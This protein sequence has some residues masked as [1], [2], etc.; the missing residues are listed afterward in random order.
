M[1]RSKE[2]RHL[3]K[4]PVITSFMRLKWGRI[5]AH[6][7]SNILFYTILVIC[8]TSYIFCT[9]GGASIGVRMPNCTIENSTGGEAAIELGQM[10]VYQT[11][12]WWALLV[13]IILL[14]LRELFQFLV[15]GLKYFISIENLIEL[16]LIISVALLQ[17]YGA[18]G[19][20]LDMKR[21]LS[22][23]ALMLSWIELITM[24][25]RHPM[26]A[27]YNTYLTMLYRVLQTFLKFLAWYSFFI[28]GFALSFYILL[29]KDEPGVTEESEY[30]F[31]DDIGLCIVKTFSMFV[32]ELEFSDLPLGSTF[33]YVFFLIFV[34]L[35]VVVLMNLLNGL[36]VSD[37]GLIREEAEIYAHVCRV[38]VI[39]AAEATI[40]GDP[41]R[42]LTGPGKIIPTC[43]LRR[44][45]GSALRL[46]YVFQ[47]L[48]GG[49]GIMLF[50]TVLPNKRLEITPNK[51]NIVCSPCLSN[52]DVG[53]D[54]IRS[55][56]NLVYSLTQQ[57]AEQNVENQIQLIRKKQASM[58][59]KL[60]AILEKMEKLSPNRLR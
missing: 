46:R 13:L 41:A 1:A 53:S 36:A 35:I 16:A 4:H 60:D 11:G 50:Y 57:E 21:Q 40:L 12:L 33:S 32:G 45:L 5:S 38:E 52:E 3:L 29:H 8:L 24:F 17:G 47:R 22:A 30:P 51:R 37:T 49:T 55:C 20:H 48:L 23:T 34:F 19:C 59:K 54:I 25:G 31:F 27:D 6:Y 43:G 2:H 10:T 44:K 26:M 56:K 18:P 9:Y 7:N 28:M 14:S 15:S 42:I 58:E 39:S